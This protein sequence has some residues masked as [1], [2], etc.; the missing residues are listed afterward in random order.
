MWNDTPN[1]DACPPSSII[2]L[3]YPRTDGKGSIKVS[4]YDGGLLP[5]R[6]EELSP[7]EVVAEFEKENI[8]ARRVWKPMLN[9]I[10]FSKKQWGEGSLS[11]RIF[12]KG[13]LKELAG[14]DHVFI[15]PKLS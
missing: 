14:I 3:H 15:Q 12:K 1:V 13:I 6:P 4:W 5:P 11:E 2:H 9:Q 8:E 7:E 10:L